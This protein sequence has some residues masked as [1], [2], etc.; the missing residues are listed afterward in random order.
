MAL[1][2]ELLK[3]LYPNHSISA[4]LL[5][6]ETPALIEIPPARLAAMLARLTQA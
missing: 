5:F 1:Y 4:A 3:S 2:A 6:T